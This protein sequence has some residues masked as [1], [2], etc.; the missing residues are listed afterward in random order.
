MKNVTAPDNEHLIEILKTGEEAFS[1]IIAKL[2]DT[3]NAYQKDKYHSMG[4]SEGDD[5]PHEKK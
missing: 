2:Q 4:E 1:K 3:P 5:N